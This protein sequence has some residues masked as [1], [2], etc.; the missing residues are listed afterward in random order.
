M[1]EAV[2]APVTSQT[3]LIRQAQAER[4]LHMALVE[5]LATSEIARRLEIDEQVVCDL[6]EDCGWGR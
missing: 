1:T 5:N 3:L 4:V 2:A 6:L